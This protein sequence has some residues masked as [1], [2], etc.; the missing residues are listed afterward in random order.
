MPG[1]LPH[2]FLPTPVLP[3]GVPLLGH[4]LRLARRPLH[5]VEELRDHGEVVVFRIGTR[6]AYMVSTGELLKDILITHQ[7]KFEKGGSL[8][9]QAR[10]LLGNGLA[11]SNGELHLRQRRLSQPAFHHS[12]MA[13][14]ARAAIDSVAAVSGSWRDGQVL[15]LGRDLNGMTMEILARTLFS[16]LTPEAAAEIRR[17]LPAL[18]AGVG[19]RAFLPVDFVHRLPL[20]VNQREAADLRRLYEVVDGIIADY[21]AGEL[22]QDDLL[23]MLML[24]RDE[25]TGEGMTT[26]QIHDEIRSMMVAGTE[27]SATL[28]LWAFHV[29]S[30]RP[31]VERRVHAELDQVLA[32]R[33]VAYTDLPR[34]EYLG[35]VIQELLR[36]YPTGWILTRRTTAEVSLGGHRIPEGADV[37]FSPYALHRDP[38]VFP[39]PDRFDPDRWLPE[40]AG[41]IPRHAFLPFGAGVRK[42]IGESLAY[43]EITIAL[44]ALAGRWRLRSVTDHPA[45]AVARST[46]RP[47]ESLMRVEARQPVE[48]RHPER[49]AP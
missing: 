23:S 27:T 34:L 41:S 44:A 11:A 9:D 18:V 28:L 10:K 14:Y 29:L 32:G 43:A 37:F 47:K 39:D 48:A 42:C 17:T 31:D 49:T 13:I 15:D 33:P 16:G 25:Q 20:P 1:T 8:F 36:M 4:A 38:A 26:H 21:R 5:F 7:S 24:A 6:P 12:R 30:S 45:R 40:R 22:D 3:G 19:R 35:R 2:A 46:L